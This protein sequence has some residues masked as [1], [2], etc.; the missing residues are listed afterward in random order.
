M[1]QDFILV[2]RMQSGDEAAMDIFVRK[3]YPQ[4]LQYCTYH[5]PDKEWAKDLT[6]ETFERFFRN[7]AGYSHNGKALNLLYTIARNLCI[8]WGRKKRESPGGEGEN[9]GGITI[10]DSLEDGCVDKMDDKILMES[11]MKKL[12]DELREVVVLHYFQ[13]LSMR[14]LAGILQIGVPLA[15]YRIKRAKEILREMLGDVE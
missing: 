11:A 3:Y 10:A 7:L 13:G 15:K 6:Q 5:C 1:Q 14:E 12:P 8:D 4:I 2:R 9:I